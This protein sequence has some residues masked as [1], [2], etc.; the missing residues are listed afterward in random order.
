LRI[1]AGL[2][3]GIAVV[4]HFRSD[5]W[6]PLLTYTLTDL[7]VLLTKGMC[8]QQSPQSAGI[9]QGCLLSPF[10]FRILMTVLMTNVQAGVSNAAREAVEKGN[11]EYVRLHICHEDCHQYS[12]QKWRE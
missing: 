3:V 10:L 8:L 5:N 4:W 12:E 7:P 6:M 2:V 11:L 1:G 9:S